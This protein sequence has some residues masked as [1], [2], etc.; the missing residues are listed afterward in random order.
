MSKLMTFCRMV[1]GVE[2]VTM[3]V[4]DDVDLTSMTPKDAHNF[5]E[6]APSHMRTV[7]LELE[8][9]DYPHQVTPY[10][11]LNKDANVAEALTETIYFDKVY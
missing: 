4:D 5:I 2:K 6:N 7:D 11:L 8:E 9:N 3:F 1:S 10:R